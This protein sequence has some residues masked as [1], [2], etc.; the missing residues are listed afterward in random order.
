[1]MVRFREFHVKEGVLE[2][3]GGIG[4]ADCSP[5][6]SL[7]NFCGSIAMDE[8]VMRWL[9][10]LFSRES[11]WSLVFDD[12]RTRYV[13]GSIFKTKQNLVSHITI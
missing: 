9:G 1:M 4:V 5:G 12:E 3:I 6:E 13:S 8:R 7:G 11:S 10:P 2:G